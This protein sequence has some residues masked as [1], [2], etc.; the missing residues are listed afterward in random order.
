[1]SARRSHRRLPQRK[2]RL[3]STKLFPFLFVLIVNSLKAMWSQVRCT[4]AHHEWGVFRFLLFAS[5]H[6]AAPSLQVC[7][8]SSCL[9]PPY[10]TGGVPMT[11]GALLG[12]SHVGPVLSLQFLFRSP[13]RSSQLSCSAVSMS[14]RARPAANA[15]HPCFR[16]RAESSRRLGRSRRS[17]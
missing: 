16:P 1:M 15:G 12:G 4:L 9:A 14:F 10:R 11:R 3:L 17:L 8:C 7:S 6:L 2:K 13:T 5:H